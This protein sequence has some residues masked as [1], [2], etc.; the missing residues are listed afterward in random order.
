MKWKFRVNGIRI[1]GLKTIGVYTFDETNP[2]TLYGGEDEEI[3]IPLDIPSTSQDAFEAMQFAPGERKNALKLPLT[4]QGFF[5]IPQVADGVIA[6]NDDTSLDYQVNNAYVEL[7]LQ[8]MMDETDVGQ[9]YVYHVCRF[10]IGT[11]QIQMLMAFKRFVYLLSLILQVQT[12][13][14][15]A[16]LWYLI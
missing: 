6:H 8:G 13:V 3:S 15:R 12:K 11:L 9:G 1:G 7:D 2:W 16:I 4:D 10:N 5:L 14:P